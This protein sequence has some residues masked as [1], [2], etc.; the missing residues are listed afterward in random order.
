MTD[1]QFLDDN[2]TRFCLNTC[3][4]PLRPRIGLNAVH[5]AIWCAE[6]AIK[7]L[8]NDQE[9]QASP[10][11][12]GSVAE[13]DIEPMLPHVG[14]VDIMYYFNSTLAMP[15]GHQTPTQLPDEFQNYVR[16]YNIIDSQ[17]PGYVYLKLHC[18]L[19]NWTSII[20]PFFT[21]K[22]KKDPSYKA[23]YYE[24]RDCYLSIH[25]PSAD[26]QL[27]RH[28]PAYL[29]SWQNAELLSID[30]VYC[31]RCLSWP[32]QAAEWPTRRRNY[33]WP[34]SATVDRV[35][36]NGCD[37]VQVAHRQCRE[38]EWMNKYQWR[39]SFSRAEIVQINNWL[40]VQQIAYHIL[41]VFMKSEQLTES[42]NSQGEGACMLSNYHI[43]TLT[44]WACEVKPKSWWTDDLSLIRICVELLRTLADW[45]TEA[46]CP[47]YFITNCNLVDNSFALETIT[48]RLLSIDRKLLSS[49]FVNDY[50]R[51]SVRICPQ[52]VSRLFDDVSTTMKLE[53]AVSA[54]V[55][56]RLNTILPKM[57]H[58]FRKA[59][60][61]I[62]YLPNSTLDV[63]S[64][65]NLLMTELSK[66]D[67]HL[68][69]YFVGVTFLHGADK[70]ARPLSMENFMNVITVASTLLVRLSNYYNERTFSWLNKDIIVVSECQ[71]Q[72]TNSPD[73]YSP[74][75]VELLTQTAVE[76]LTTFREL[77]ARDFGSAA[78]IVTTDFEALYAYKRGNY[79]QCLELSTQNVDTL[80]NAEHMPD[81]ATLSEFVQLLDD[82]IVSLTALT[83]IVNPECREYSLNAT[84]TQL[85]LSLY[86]MTQCQLKLRHSLSS[87]DDTI[88]YIAVAQKRHGVHLTLDRLTLKLIERKLV[89]HITTENNVLR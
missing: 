3:Q 69:V 30:E 16:V 76:L 22:H 83:L 6:N 1:E 8:S 73:H 19:I 62:A 53:N 32:P 82:D 63:P 5:A 43:K 54:A 70:I 37:L 80:L 36:S 50:I 86:L 67:A 17:L 2:V 77:E 42:T 34:D 71:T 25:N 7:R 51:Q 55:A 4:L 46:R 88:S 68:C 72:A 74:G 18:F 24:A 13:F 57:W 11:I 14:D 20:G 29:R 41:R 89:T 26:H 60:Y 65:R 59:E 33:G 81:V 27:E 47:H 40:P 66:V 45:L 35:V 38:D 85:T 28:G 10:L 58:A 84:V 31:V 48:S 39:L 49:W 9:V 12:T 79:Q 56:W 87:L 15:Q 23:T 21:R 61:Q 52:S 78:T 64:Y 75:F 44:L